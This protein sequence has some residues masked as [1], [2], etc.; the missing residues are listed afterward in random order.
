MVLI[1]HE[2]VKPCTENV[3]IMC[4]VLISHEHVKPCTENVRI[5]CMVLMSYEHVKPCTAAHSKLFRSTSCHVHALKVS[6]MK[7]EV[8]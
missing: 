6:L 8:Q 7:Q 4:M 5:L 3:R 2:H 1:S